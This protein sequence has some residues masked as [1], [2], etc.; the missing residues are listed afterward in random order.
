MKIKEY[1]DYAKYL[2]CSESVMGWID[3]TLSNYLEKN[4][5][6]QSEVEHVLDY[7]AQNEVKKIQ[8]MSYPEGVKKAEKWI[9]K[10]NK[11]AEKIEESDD[12]TKLILDF[13]DGFK[14]VQL[15]GKRAYEREGNL[16]RHCVASYYGRDTKIYSLR[17]A[18]NNPHCTIE[19]L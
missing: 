16:M 6:E 4:Q 17:D 10:L 11:K 13:K 5:P 12:D 1:K 2:N 8:M 18:Q 7:L 9:I 3:T 14:I 19:I 15:I